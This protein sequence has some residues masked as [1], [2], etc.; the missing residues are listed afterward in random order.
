M[1]QLQCS[2]DQNIINKAMDQSVKDFEYEFMWSTVSSST[3]RE[4]TVTVCELFY[5][6]WIILCDWLIFSVVYWRNDNI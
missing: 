5:C 2:L 4:L 3:P 1:I 6:V